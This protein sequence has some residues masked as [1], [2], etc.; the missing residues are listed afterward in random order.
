MLLIKLEGVEM[1]M[2]LEE[3]SKKK[4]EKILFKKCFDFKNKHLVSPE[5]LFEL[6]NDSMEA[7]STS[8]IEFE[9]LY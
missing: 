1:T 9:I 8:K 4:F 2:S 5:K 7:S 6:I 3:K